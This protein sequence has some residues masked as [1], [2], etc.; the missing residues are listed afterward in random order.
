MRFIALVFCLCAAGFA[1]TWSGYLVDSNCWRNRQE[2][3]SLDTSLVSRDMRMDLFYCL[4]TAKTKRFAVV[5]YDW[6]A[7]RL[8]AAGNE[9]AADLV[10][11]A[12][13]K[14]LLDV[15]VTGVL[16]RKTI[17]AASIPSASLRKR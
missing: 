16:D 1:E 10:R 2:N 14:P 5:L 3:V 12:G 7:L 4:P 13:K 15:T 8:D 11:R 9:R 6:S 17:Q